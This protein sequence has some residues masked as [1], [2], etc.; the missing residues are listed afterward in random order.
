MRDHRQRPVVVAVIAVRMMQ[1]P[2][3]EVVDMVAVGDGFM[4]AARSVN[5]PCLRF[6]AIGGVAAVRILVGDGNLVLLDLAGLLVQK[7][8]VLEIVNVVVVSDGRAAVPDVRMARGR[9]DRHTIA[10]LRAARPAM[11]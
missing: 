4:A 9:H 6:H 7:A 2:V 3:H 1:A 5:M 10:T 11:Q 8:A